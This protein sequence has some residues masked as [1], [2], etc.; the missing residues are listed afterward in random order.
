[1]AISKKSSPSILERQLTSYFKSI[2]CKKLKR[3]T[4]V[5]FLLMK[6]KSTKYDLFLF[7]STLDFDIVLEKLVLWGKRQIPMPQKIESE[8]VIALLQTRV[9]DPRYHKDQKIIL[10]PSSAELNFAFKR[11]QTVSD[12][13]KK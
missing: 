8:K 10:I 7:S 12:F 4:G 13:L 2:E 9:T 3:Q 6:E 5:L 11:A 1:M